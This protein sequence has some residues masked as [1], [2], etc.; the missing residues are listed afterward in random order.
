VLAIPVSILALLKL[1]CLKHNRIHLTRPMRDDSEAVAAIVDALQPVLFD[2][3]ATMMQKGTIGS[4]M[5]F[6]ASGSCK[7]VDGNKTLGFRGPG[8]MVGEISLVYP[9]GVQYSPALRT[10]T[11][12]N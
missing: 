4:Y 8:D 10:V 2:A 12:M 11:R 5:L 1:T 3:D 6:I 7:I 9:T